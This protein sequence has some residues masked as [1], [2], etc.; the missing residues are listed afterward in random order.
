MLLS[1]LR[2][3]TKLEAALETCIINIHRAFTAQEPLKDLFQCY[4][5]GVFFL[6]LLIIDVFFSCRMSWCSYSI[7]ERKIHST[8]LSSG[9]KPALW[10]SSAEW[11]RQTCLESKIKQKLGLSLTASILMELSGRWVWDRRLKSSMYPLWIPLSS[12]LFLWN[13]H[14]LSLSQD[15]WLIGCDEGKNCLCHC[16]FFFPASFAV[17]LWSSALFTANC[18]DSAVRAENT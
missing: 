14:L 12:L 4:W 7:A 11:E 3:E 18:S 2:S 8:Q 15:S 1:Q 9:D 17:N 6:W 13:N 16:F 5:C 10:P